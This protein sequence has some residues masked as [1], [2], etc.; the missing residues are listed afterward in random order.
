VTANDIE[1]VSILQQ[2]SVSLTKSGTVDDTIVSPSGRPDPGDLIN[3]RFDVTNTGNVT[4]S[5]LAVVD[6]SVP[7]VTCPADD[8]LPGDSVQCT[9]TYPITQDDIDNGNVPNTATAYGTPPIGDPVS[10]EGGTIVNIAQTTSIDIAMSSDTPD[11]ETLGEVVGYDLVVT[12]TG[13]VG[14]VDVNVSDANADAGSIVCTPSLPVSLAPGATASCTALHTV[15]QTDLDGGAIANV[16]GVTARGV[17]GVEVSGSSNEVIVSAVQNPALEATKTAT[18]EPIGDGRFSVAYTIS[19]TNTGN[20]TATG[21]TIADELDAVFGADGYTV[22][23]LSS[24]HLT[25]NLG[26]DGRSDTDLLTGADSLAPGATGIVRLEITTAPLGSKGPF[27]NSAS[28]DADGSGQPVQAVA[29]VSTELDVA[30]DLTI[31]KSTSGSVAPGNDTTWTI[32]VANGGPSATFGPIT[33]TDTLNDQLTFVSATG[34]GWM[35]SHAHG[36]VTCQRDGMLDAGASSTV[37]IVT[38]V[39]AAIGTS[40]SNQASVISADSVNESDPANNTDVAS[41]TVDSLPVTGIDTGDFGAIA[42]ASILFGLLLLVITG[43]KR[44]VQAR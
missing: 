13:N 32:V 5:S 22:D 26:Y 19:V 2:P 17:N 44:S 39:N 11:Y 28:V 6:P 30:F 24:P 36:T 35:C 8:V 9:G 10:A 3:Y 31:D 25:V 15:T 20:V 43:R 4:L 37:S 42:I 1:S 33:V 34:T 38:T 27:V 7:T 29:G 21:V 23:D 41:V 12:N 16:A 14:L 40:V 18:S